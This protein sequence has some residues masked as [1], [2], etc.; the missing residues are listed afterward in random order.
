LFDCALIRNFRANAFVGRVATECL[1]A[2]A[3][4]DR[5]GDVDFSFIEVLVDAKRC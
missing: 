3:L 1:L 5:A 2:N 4:T